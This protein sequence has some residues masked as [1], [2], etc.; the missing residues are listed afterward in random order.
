MNLGATINQIT[1]YM[2]S[3]MEF[4]M[5]GLDEQREIGDFFENLDDLIALRQRELEGIKKKKKALAQLLL[6]GVIRVK[7]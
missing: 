3:K 7:P 1:G 5:P 4:N 6:T 2:F